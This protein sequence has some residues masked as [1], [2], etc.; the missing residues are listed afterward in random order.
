MHNTLKTIFKKIYFNRKKQQAFLE[1]LTSLLNDG[2]SLKEAATMIEAISDGYH[3]KIA[4]GMSQALAE[5]KTIADGLT[6]WFPA[7]TLEIIRAGENTGTLHPALTAATTA[8]SQRSH[9]T[10]HLLSILIYPMIVLILA[11][12]M[13]VIIKNTVLTNF[14]T[15]KPIAEWPNQGASLYYLAIFIERCWWVM[16]SALLLL[17]YVTFQ[18]LTNYTGDYRQKID[19]YPLLGLYRDTVAAQFMQTLGI[20]MSNGIII[21]KALEILAF[22]ARPYLAWH[23]MMMEYQLSG[24]IDNIA[25][26]LNTQLLKPNELLRLKIIAKGKGFSAALIKL[27]HQASQRNQQFT[28]VAGRILGGII[29]LFG[30]AIAANIIFGIYAIGSI[31]TH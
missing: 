2:V 21:K 6:D 26:V 13:L 7:T 11:M 28:I 3:K 31:L 14:A 16:L 4:S 25:E 29:L 5:G 10:T 1:D 20:L 23:I 17:S 27:G 30:A 9:I 12:L 19:D 22:N 24:G 18:F 8:L 15:I